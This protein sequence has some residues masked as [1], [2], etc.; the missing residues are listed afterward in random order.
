MATGQV[1]FQRF[2][3]TASL[4]D[5]ALIEIVL[6][7]LFLACKIEETSRKMRD[8]INVIDYLIKY[9]RDLPFT[10][11]SIYSEQYYNFK[12]SMIRGEILILRQLGFNVQVELPYGLLVNYLKALNLSDAS[13]L[14]QLAWNYLN[15]GLRTKIYVAYD[16][17]TLACGVI[18]LACRT[19]EIPMPESP[20]WWELF[21]AELE[22]IEQIA[23]HILRLYTR[24]VDPKLPIFESE[25]KDYLRD[26][27]RIPVKREY[28]SSSG[29]GIRRQESNDYLKRS[30]SPDLND[31]YRAKSVRSNS[32][33]TY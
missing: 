20:P 12:D 22:D 16:L 4:K 13:S 26:Y 2:Y 24:K 7:A 17:P 33:D 29:E 8:I 25:L 27:C 21:G 31:D 11:L 28:N 14:P 10:P 32:S 18:F 19:C 9:K 3:Y 15:D 23:N 1:L 5:H 6:G 30:A